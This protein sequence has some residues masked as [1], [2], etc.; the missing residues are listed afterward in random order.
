MPKGM[1]KLKG[2]QFLSDYIVGK[3]EENKIKELGALANLHQSLSIT[4]LENVV[5]SNEASEARMCDKDGINS[6]SLWWSVDKDEN[7]VDSQIERDILDKLR[8]HSNLK[9]LQIRGYR[10]TT[11]PDWMDT[12]IKHAN[13]VKVR[14]KF[15]DDQNRH[16][17]RNVKGPDKEIDTSII[18]NY[19]VLQHDLFH[20]F[21]QS[22]MFMSFDNVITSASYIPNLF[23]ENGA[24]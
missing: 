6:L 22:K 9:E 12:G 8:P 16:I 19:L 24:K 15:L 20:M 18:T 2:L 13:I 17:M 5:N 4:K 7:T 14:V 21:R 23:Y 3:H 10:G 11:L 1:S